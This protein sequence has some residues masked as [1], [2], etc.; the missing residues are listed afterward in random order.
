MASY[1]LPLPVAVD[2]D[3]A[4]FNGTGQ[5]KSDNDKTD[6]YAFRAVVKP[7]ADLNISGNYAG[8][9]LQ[10]NKVDMFDLGAGYKLNGLSLA[11]EYAKR[12][13]TV[14]AADV[15]LDS[16][17]AYA[18]YDIALNSDF[19]KFISPA[20]R[21]EYFE[22][23]SNAA[24]DEFNRMTFGLTFSFAKLTFAH[25]RINYETFN[26]KA[27]YKGTDKISDR[28]VFEYQIRF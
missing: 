2:I 8:G 22:P 26:Y 6:N 24:N 28:L 14:N 3:A 9:I 21:Y 13:A 27:D 15:S 19:I 16:Y 11:G 18:I 10:G 4:A 17:F 7:I 5:N 1:S 25:F 20:V 12:T 23:N